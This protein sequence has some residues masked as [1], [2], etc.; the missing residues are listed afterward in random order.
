MKL[1]PLVALVLFAVACQ[2]QRITL[3]SYLADYEA[4]ERQDFLELT[5]SVSSFKASLQEAIAEA[6]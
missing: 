1:G 5:V 2:G 4:E 6:R 3:L